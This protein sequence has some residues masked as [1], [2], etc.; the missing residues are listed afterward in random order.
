M[1]AVPEF[2]RSKNPTFSTES[3]DSILGTA[4]DTSQF[5]VFKT[6]MYAYTAHGL[7]G[8]MGA[9]TLRVAIGCRPH[10]VRGKFFVMAPSFWPS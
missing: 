10:T 8:V 7:Q 3:A 2:R 6:S 4:V 1:V 5:A 9:N